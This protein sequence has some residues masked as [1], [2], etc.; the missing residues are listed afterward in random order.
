MSVHLVCWLSPDHGL[1]AGPSCSCRP[2][3]AASTAPKTGL[4]AGALPGA[5][6]LW[7]P[8]LCTRS[9]RSDC[10]PTSSCRCLF[11][12]QIPTVEGPPTS[13]FT[14]KQEVAR[15]PVTDC[16][17]PAFKAPSAPF[18][19]LSLESRAPAA[20]PGQQAAA[21]TAGPP[22]LAKHHQGDDDDELLDQL[23]SLG[24]PV[25]AAPGSQ[26]VSGADRSLSVPL[27]GECRVFYHLHLKCENSARVRAACCWLSG[28]EPLSLVVGCQV[29]TK[30]KCFA[31]NQWSLCFTLK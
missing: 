30:L 6:P 27:E 26:T 23:L 8:Q 1:P 12:P 18:Q 11:L 28:N 22:Q 21:N 2:A 13:T 4:G 15:V 31:R 19:S 16:R 14:P 7:L 25:S 10:L 20:A 24:Q 17:V 5:L 9:L 29:T 3:A